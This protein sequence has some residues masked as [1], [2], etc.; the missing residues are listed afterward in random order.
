MCKDMKQ[1]CKR[2]EKIYIYIY[3]MFIGA[4]VP[5]FE[6]GHFVGR[7]PVISQVEPPGGCWHRCADLPMPRCP[8]SDLMYFC[9]PI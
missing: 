1:I 8:P 4:L 6:P 5:I 3:I 7:F 2:Y 9:K